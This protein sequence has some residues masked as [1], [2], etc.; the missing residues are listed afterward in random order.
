[1]CQ[2]AGMPNDSADAASVQTSTQLRSFSPLWPFGGQVGS[3]ICCNNPGAV[4]DQ[5]LLC[6]RGA[7]SLTIR[8]VYR[9]TASGV[10][11]EEGWESM[12]SLRRVNPTTVPTE[13]P[14]FLP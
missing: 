9:V 11:I 1:M 5:G 12:P 10:N 8:G 2:E 4:R 6:V 3:V 7:D 13:S 14:S